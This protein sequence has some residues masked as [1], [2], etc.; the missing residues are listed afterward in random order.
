[1]RSVRRCSRPRRGRWTSGIHPCLQTTKERQGTRKRPRSVKGPDKACTDWS[2]PRVSGL[3]QG[4]AFAYP[5]FSRSFA[6]FA[7]VCWSPRIPKLVV[8]RSSFRE[9]PWTLGHLLPWPFCL[10][11]FD[12]DGLPTKHTNHTKPKKRGNHSALQVAASVSEWKQSDRPYATRSR[13]QPLLNSCEK[14]RDRDWQK[15]HPTVLRIAYPDHGVI[16]FF[17]AF[18]EFCVPL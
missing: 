16:C 13:S 3:L 5:G 10:S 17:H 2:A 8:N 1:V 14:G 9:G 11:R 15:G 4:E 6:P 18:S 12:S 7:V